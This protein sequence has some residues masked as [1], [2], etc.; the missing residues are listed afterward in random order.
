MAA[1]GLG[2]LALVAGLGAFVVW[3]WF[4]GGLNMDQ[5]EIHESIGRALDRG[6]Q[7]GD[8]VVLE[9]S[10]AE[11][12]EVI[13]EGV[14]AAGVG[15]D[16][17]TIEIEPAGRP[18]RGRLHVRGQADDGDRTFLGRATVEA[19]D[20]RLQIDMEHFALQG[21]GLPGVADSVAGDLVAEAVSLEPLLD[22]RGLRLRDVSFAEDEMEIVAVEAEPGPVARGSR[23]TA[24]TEPEG[25]EPE[26]AEPGPSPTPGD[27]PPGEASQP[28]A[29]GDP[30]ML[31]LG[32]SVAAGV[33]VDD[34]ADSY[35]S[36]VHA[37]LQRRDEADYG[38]ANLAISGETSWSL[39]EDGQ[40]DRALT[41]LE[42][43]EAALVVVDIGAN[44]VL[45]T[46]DHPACADDLDSDRCRA[47]V[48][49]R[50]DDYR[51]NF[52]ATLT[53]LRDAA[54]R[55]PLMVMTTYNPFSFG[56]HT[57]FEQRTD[58]VVAELNRIAA[59][60]GRRHGARIADAAAPLDGRASE[61]THMSGDG[62]PDVHPNAAGY[63]ELAGAL[64]ATLQRPAPRP[65]GQALQPHPR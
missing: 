49:G 45:S 22:E 34:F 32:D 23:G 17:L 37:W 41:E 31:V 40:L 62:A 16:E 18:D 6:E 19:I 64:V 5:E 28:R 63:A 47:L 9:L 56:G 57:D 65:A 11:L 2:A 36:R 55:A 60:I 50:L 29:P 51:A 48:D 54:P 53:D 58:E 52:A 10:G 59:R 30:M 25:D 26:D 12:A 13:R 38:L 14:R 8:R 21:Y 4:T 33:G 7:T 44:D 3:P 1:V 20:G 43:R 61:L 42:R 24:D 27:V 35:V 46:L 39:R 15:V